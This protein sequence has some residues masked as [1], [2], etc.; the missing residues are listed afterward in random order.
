MPQADLSYVDKLIAALGHVEPLTRQRAAYLLGLIGETCAVP[1]LIEVLATDEDPYPRAEAAL[2]LG[3]IG[4][5]SARAALEEVSARAGQSVIVKRAA[6]RALL[7]MSKHPCT[8]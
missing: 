6:A 4:T 5:P 1:P 3:A 8:P 7:Q 2:A